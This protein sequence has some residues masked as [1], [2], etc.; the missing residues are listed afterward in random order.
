MKIFI[1]IILVGMFASV[2]LSE[3]KAVA[4]GTYID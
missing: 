1:V 3:P 4:P 2:A